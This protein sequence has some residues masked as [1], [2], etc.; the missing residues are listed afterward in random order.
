MR[1]FL[2]G[3][4]TCLLL[5]LTGCK[6]DPPSVTRQSKPA[7]G[8]KLAQLYCASC[9]QFPEPSLLNK[10]TWEQF[11]LP[12][13]GY[14]FGIYDHPAERAA[15][16]ENN[17]GGNIVLE[18][19]LFPAEA[20]LDS[21][22]WHAITQYYLSEAPDSLPLPP[23]KNI[24]KTLSQFEV[25]IPKQKVRIPSSTLVQFSNDGSLYL[26]DAMTQSFTVFS[27]ALEVVQTGNLAEGVVSIEIIENRQWLTVMGSFSPTDAPLGSIVQMPIN[28]ADA[29]ETVIDRL[30]RPVHA[31]YAD[32]NNDGESD[33]VVCEFGKWTGALSLFLKN[34]Q[35]YRKEVLHPLPG[36][37]KAYIQDMNNDGHQDIVA[38]FAQGDEGID[39]FYNDGK[40]N[41]TRE[42]VLSFSPSMGSSFFNLMDYNNDGA[43]DIVFTAGDNADYKPVLKPWHGVYVFT[44]NGDNEFKQEVFVHLNGAYNAVVNDFDG[45]GDMDIAAIS[46]FPDWVNSPEESF[47]YFQKEGD[48]YQLQTFPEVNVGRWI[49]MDAADYDGD[50]DLDLVLG[51]LAFEVI[52]KLGFVE[53][54]MASGVPFVVLENSQR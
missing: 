9:H 38:L 1:I 51:S 12:R 36:A 27:D 32:L 18:S 35:G 39:I 17:E 2:L 11:M 47:V 28:Q 43:L 37:I 46:F 50:G 23:E 26:G 22:T 48:S 10:D 19:G 52:P 6:N 49:V 41:F 15:L 3:L 8:E 45:D 5:L 21:T 31:S 20:T 4:S 30:Q 13:M 24:S 44:N 54:W 16:F 25:H 33:I 42:R 14:M 34:A 40:A 29:A 53:K 7:S